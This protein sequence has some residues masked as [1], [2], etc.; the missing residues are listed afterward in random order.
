MKKVFAILLAAL[1]VATM[2]VTAFAAEVDQ[3]T[4]DK[5]GSTAVSFNVDPTYTVTIPA[6]VELEKV[7]TDGTITYEKDMTVTA[8]AGVRLKEGEKIEVTLASDFYLETAASATY[9]LPY[10]V[11][12]NGAAIMNNGT[13]AV[14]ETSEAEQTSTLRFA[15]DD[16]TYAGNYTD[17]VTFTISVVTE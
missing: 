15:A 7:D 16:P 1:M 4:T 2:S 11:T 13:V 8:S 3:D 17:T 9:K 6:T 5:T 12:V 10:A 14:F